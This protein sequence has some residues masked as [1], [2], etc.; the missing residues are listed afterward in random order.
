MKVVGEKSFVPALSFLGFEE[1]PEEINS[2][3]HPYRSMNT[4]CRSM[5]GE[6]HM[7]GTEVRRERVGGRARLRRALSCL[8]PITMSEIA[9]SCQWGDETDTSR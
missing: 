8:S 5:Q 1:R 2:M 7:K 6:F 4:F 3:F 9:S